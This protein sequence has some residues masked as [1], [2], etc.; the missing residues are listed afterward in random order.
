MKILRRITEPVPGEQALATAPVISPVTQGGWRRRLNLFTGRA[1]GDTALRAEQDHRAGHLATLGQTFSH[2]VV[3]GL[4]VDREVGGTADA[5]LHSLHVA[6]GLG[7]TAAGEDVVVP[8]ALRVP[9]DHLWAYLTTGGGSAPP[10]GD[11]NAPEPPLEALPLGAAFAQDMGPLFPPVPPQPEFIGPWEQVRPG[12]TRARVFPRAM[13]LVLEP[14]AAEVTRGPAGTDECEQDPANDAFA[15][16]QV[17]DG[18]RLALYAWPWPSL[19]GNPDDPAFRNRLADTLFRIE[20]GYLPGQVHPWEENGV[21]LALLGFDAQFG[22]AWVDSNAVVRG[23]GKPR[24]RSS[25]MAGGGNPFLWRARIQQFAEEA[26]EVSWVTG[27]GARFRRLPPVGLLP[28]TAALELENGELFPAGWEVDAVPVPEDQLD[29]AVAMSASLAPYDLSVPRDRVRVLVPVPQEVYHPRLLVD[30]VVSPAFQEAIDLFSER[31]REFLYRRED[32]RRKVEAIVEAYTG[33]RPRLPRPEDDPERLEDEGT[34]PPS[35]HSGTRSHLSPA[36]AGE[37][38][39]HY[40]IRGFHEVEAGEILY[41]WIYLNAREMPEQVVLRWWA[42]SGWEY[43]AYWGEPRAPEPSAVHTSVRMGDLP[44]AG[45]WVRLEIPAWVVRIEADS[46]VGMN[47][48]VFGGGAVWDRA[49]VIP[50]SDQQWFNDSVP[51]GTTVFPDGPWELVSSQE[52]G[53]APPHVG[54][55]ALRVAAPPPGQVPPGGGLPAAPVAQRS[56]DKTPTV[57]EVRE[58]D[59]LFAYVRLERDAVPSAVMLQWND[60][61]WEHRAYWGADLINL[62]EAGTPSRRYGG[63]LPEAGRWVRLQMPAAALELEGTR[64]SGFAFTVYG[65]AAQVTAVGV[66]RARDIPP[67]TGLTGEYFTDENFSNLRLSR[68]DRRILLWQP[69]EGTSDDPVYD[70]QT[71]SIRWTGQLRAQFTERYTFRL[72]HTGALARLVVNGVEL[73]NSVTAFTGRKQPAGSTNLQAGKRY[74]VLLEYRPF[75]SDPIE[76]TLDWFSLNQRV[77]YIAPRFLYPSRTAGGTALSPRPEVAW[78]DDDVPPGAVTGANNRAATGTNE[79]W[80]W[81]TPPVYLPPEAD[82]RTDLAEGVRRAVPMR[83]LR[84]ALERASPLREDER[85]QLDRL[86]LER[87][88]AWLDAKVRRCDDV[89][90]FGFVRVQADMYRLRQLMLGT[91]AATR[92]ATSPAL[93][94]IIQGESA[95]Q[96]REGLLDFLRRST[97]S[98]T[99][100]EADPLGGIAGGSTDPAGGGAV[101]GAR[102]DDGVDEGGLPGEVEPLAPAADDTSFRAFSFAAK[103]SVSTGESSLSGSRTFAAPAESEPAPGTTLSKSFSLASSTLKLPATEPTPIISAERL[104]AL[105]QVSIAST[106]QPVTTPILPRRPAATDEVLL[107]QPIVGETYDFRTV[108]VG[109]RLETPAANEAKSFTTLTRYE[110]LSALLT[111]DINLDD[112]PVPGF[113]KTEG[114]V[115]V[116]RTGF[117]IGGKPVRIP[118][119]E[120]RLLGQVRP[121]VEDVTLREPDPEDADEPRFFSVGVE[122]LDATI[123]ALRAVE[124]RVQQYRDA[125]A[126]CR[127]TLMELYRQA[128]S[129]DARMKVVEEELAEARH[130]V[131]VARALLAEETARVQQV[132]R[133]RRE[134]LD[135]SVSFLAWHRPRVSDGLRAA[136][137]RPLD[138]ALTANPVPECLS[139]PAHAPAEL[140]AVVR[141]LRESPVRWFLHLPRLLDDL[142]RP[143]LLV[144]TLRGARARAQVQGVPGMLE[145]SAGGGGK[146]GEAIGQ[147]VAA[148]QAVVAETKRA[149]AAIDLGAW[150]QQ[151]WRWLRD[152]AELVLSPGDLIDGLHGR[153]DVGRVA[154]RELDDVLRVAT[155]LYQR[156]GQVPA[157]VRLEWTE[158]LSQFD[159]AADLRNLYSLPRWATLDYLDRREL[160]SLVDWLFQRVDPKRPEAVALMNDVVRVCILLASHAPVNQLLAGKV[161]RA[162]EVR[163]GAILPLEVDLGRVRVGMHVLAYDELK[164]PVRAVVEDMGG[165]QVVSRVV[166]APDEA[167]TLPVGTRVQVGAQE[168]LEL[169]AELPRQLDRKTEVLDEFGVRLE[170]LREAD[171]GAR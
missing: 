49:G 53:V 157:L 15:D 127:N 33:T 86:G 73:F 64:L 92:L 23:G 44:P 136:P 156:F 72:T 133:H 163:I 1:L 151:G 22:V 42:Y 89:V 152:K 147:R 94:S 119:R 26:N 101:V 47:F 159:Q 130:D 140:R 146:L 37:H 34:I 13:V 30:E 11:P 17:A 24:A 41:A 85:A 117:S 57:V 135:R 21:A 161:A 108:T 110:V 167:V 39:H 66:A 8:Q 162:S 63:P 77:D 148:Q 160:Q 122:L 129:L 170:R 35:P 48:G 65:G 16:W 38:Y 102:V 32:L 137:M 112:L 43:R 164:R 67:G 120:P 145:L 116:F 50:S 132:N 80:Q 118:V 20:A 150:E 90:N 144:G 123:A 91:T 25:L 75:G 97:I 52:G 139:Q 79:G 154:A 60:G 143:E 74:D 138:P 5:P 76:L 31:R 18:S 87:F 2:G 28:R 78:V 168:H 3:K 149:I 40:I 51:T 103:A 4:E 99:S 69:T 14:V 7:L 54:F 56:F 83:E 141:L 70:G 46:V 128:R 126:L 61:S 100:P 95:L 131:A 10:T 104:A 12:G 121:V 9:L 106:F 124:G 169:S 158:R 96:V 88:I 134:V 166:Q 155:C 125:L 111:L 98:S 114:G 68:V 45:Q 62:G 107:K 6:P 81:Y 59:A 71:R 84:T 165:G 93:A 82:Y 105:Q 115:P 29:A 55:R 36:A 153:T 27:T 58:G 113:I 109:E 171:A 19:L 142:D